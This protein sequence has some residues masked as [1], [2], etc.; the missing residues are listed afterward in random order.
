MSDK[1]NAFSFD[2]FFAED[3][4]RK[5]KPQ[6]ASI[7]AVTLLE[8]YDAN[9]FLNMQILCI[10]MFLLLENFHFQLNL[11]TS[12]SRHLFLNK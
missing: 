10:K 9:F 7:Y 5:L 6:I 3:F 11:N 4:W 12:H 2:D 8:Q 1:T